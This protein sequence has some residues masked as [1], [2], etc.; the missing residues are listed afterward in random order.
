MYPVRIA[1]P[2]QTA[3]TLATT[4]AAVTGLEVPGLD[5]SGVTVALLDTVSTPRTRT[6]VGAC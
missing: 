1:Y 3:E 6:C 4:T 5:G 2:A